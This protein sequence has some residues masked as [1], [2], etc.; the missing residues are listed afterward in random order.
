MKMY[1]LMRKVWMLALMSLIVL[2]NVAVTQAA[3][4]EWEAKYW[5]NKNLSG[6]PV[7]VRQEAELN[8][9]WGAG[10]PGPV[11]A[12]NF[13]ARFKRTID[14][15]AGDYRF[16]ATMDDGLRFW[17]DDVLIIDSWVTADDRTLSA[18]VYLTGG[19]HRL[20]VEYFDSVGSALVK[21]SW[22]T[23]Q[24]DPNPVVSDWRGEYFNN[25][26]LSGT[27]VMVR[28]E[29]AIN[30]N[31]G[32]GAPAGGL[33]AADQ[34]SARWTRD[35]NLEA[36]RYRFT[37]T[38]DDGMR[39]WVNGRLLIDKWVDQAATTVS[40][41]ID[42]PGGL[43]PVQMN[44]YENVGGASATL[45]WVRVNST[46]NI[47]S[48]RGEY[49][50]N[51]TL[52]GTPVLVRDDA[53]IAFNWGTGSPAEGI[54][55]D[56][57]SVRWSRTLHNVAP[58][59]YRF[60][61]NTD[62]GVRLWVNGQL[63]INQWN[64]HQAQDFVGDLNFAGGTMDIVM[65]YYENV[66]GAR[67]NM[68]RTLVSSPVPPTPAPT[69]ITATVASARLNV[70]QGPSVTTPIITVYE[71]GRV[72]NLVGRNETAT[73]VQIILHDGSRGWVYSPLLTTSGNLA[74]LP[75]GNGIAST[76]ITTT[77]TTAVV[78]N[79][80]YALNVRSAPDSTAN[81]V[82]TAIQRGTV[83]TLLGRNSS[84]T[85]LQIQLADGTTGWSS[86]TYLTTSY[87]IANLPITN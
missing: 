34:F 25:M 60:T 51:K 15:P 39:L 13:S 50:N 54:N 81:N 61:A 56:G 76:P 24:L 47:T 9:D 11:N 66:G 82:I 72:L 41:E 38:A 2:T 42:L 52:S 19:D 45:S 70:R 40:A 18:D 77:G 69:G 49:F 79:A 43:I 64:D 21:L 3:S 22:V 57:F 16:T 33:V 4:T 20:K 46:G 23:L 85:W 53:N 1:K 78:S 59:T 36:G 71:Q 8:H 35:M 31:W 5:N 7:L 14:V 30:F 32:V 62:D 27:P 10:A 63:I 67:A 83:V 29:T 86:A 80:V 74:T 17:I 65:E 6:E 12:N 26:T 84:N 55:K 68:T 73:W 58:G 37:A 87:T 75:L 48:W 44:Y 28:N